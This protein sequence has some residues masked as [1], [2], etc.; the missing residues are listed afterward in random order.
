MVLI[1]ILLL[2]AFTA[3]LMVAVGS[4]RHQLTQSFSEIALEFVLA[5]FTYNINLVMY[6]GLTQ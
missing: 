5:D 6:E 3:G 4:W 1:E 2:K